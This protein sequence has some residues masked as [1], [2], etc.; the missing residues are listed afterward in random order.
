MGFAPVHDR[1]YVVRLRMLICTLTV[2]VIELFTEFKQRF[3][4]QNL[5]SWMRFRM[6]VLTI[7]RAVR[8]YRRGTGRFL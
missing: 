3:S 1:V 6:A 5:P 8:F 7:L 4:V 2:N